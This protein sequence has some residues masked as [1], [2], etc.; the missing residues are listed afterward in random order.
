MPIHWSLTL[1]CETCGAAIRY[2]DE[3]PTWRIE[4]P[5]PA[6]IE[7]ARA[8]VAENPEV[9][10]LEPLPPYVGTR[11]I[12]QGV[13]VTFVDAPPARRYV[14]C[15]A[16]DGRVWLDPGHEPEAE[17]PAGGTAQAG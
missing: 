12:G 8:W 7:Q 1:L 3:R 9:P 10:S 5:D 11:P 6:L 16:C 2:E 4:E 14:T 17:E 13:S 15:P